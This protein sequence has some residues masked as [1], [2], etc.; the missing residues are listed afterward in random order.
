MIG[1]LR[2]LTVNRD[3]TQNVTVT[4]S[5][6]FSK[7]FDALKDH[8]LSIEIKKAGKGRSKDANAFCWALCSEIG[9]SMTPPLAKEEVYR[10]AIKAVGVF[11]ET[12]L[13]AFDVQTVRER[14]ESHGEGWLFEVIDDVHGLLG[15]KVVHLYYGSST[16][17]VDEMKTL[18]DWLVDQAEQM[19][20]P[21]RLSRKEEQEMLERWGMK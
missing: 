13:L 12:Q 11:T 14:W 9:R 3:G 16:Y 8:E 4:V 18:I 7:A 1:K 5:C 2:D 15:H 21:V 19:E 10:M 6:D 20:L 17:T